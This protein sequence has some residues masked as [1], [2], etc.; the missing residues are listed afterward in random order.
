VSDG[1][2]VVEVAAEAVAK[3]PLTGL[4][5][6]GDAVAGVATGADWPFD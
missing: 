3:T 1:L 4:N 2:V 6:T 5:F